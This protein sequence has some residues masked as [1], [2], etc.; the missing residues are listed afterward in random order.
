MVPKYTT[1]QERAE[2]LNEVRHG[3][4]PAE[5]QEMF[6]EL[7][8]LLSLLLLDNPDDRPTAD[9]AL[10]KIH[11]CSNIHYN[12]LLGKTKPEL[13]DA[14]CRL[15][16]YAKNLE[17]ALAEEKRKTLMEHNCKCDDISSSSHMSKGTEV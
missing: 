1:Q 2:T 9:Q 16:A 4:I 17:K 6:P 12:E 5:T 11:A 15:Q 3:N 10:H 13:A 7:C 8:S 14:I